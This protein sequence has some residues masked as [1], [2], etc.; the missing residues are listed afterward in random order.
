MRFAQ[1]ANAKTNTTNRKPIG[2]NGE[3][4]P[5]LGSEFIF[6]PLETKTGGVNLFQNKYFA[7]VQERSVLD[8]NFIISLNQLKNEQ[9]YYQNRYTNY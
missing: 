2:Q 7:I 4:W 1:S 6:L 3:I 9:K 5:I 8:F